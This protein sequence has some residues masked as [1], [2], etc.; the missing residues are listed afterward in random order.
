MCF[1]AGLTPFG[2]SD[3]VAIAASVIYLGITTIPIIF[4]SLVW[5][6]QYVLVKGKAI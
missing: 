3:E 6:F 1:L 5:Y 4:V 2:V